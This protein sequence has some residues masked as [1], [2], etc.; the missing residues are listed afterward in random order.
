MLPGIDRPEGS[1][2]SLHQV[3]FSSGTV[4]PQ[5]LQT[6]AF[7]GKVAP[8]CLHLRKCPRISWVGLLKCSTIR[9]NGKTPDNTPHNKGFFPLEIASL[10]PTAAGR[11]N[12]ISKKIISFIT[13]PSFIQR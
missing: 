12:N 6:E 9:K 10:N 8:H 4:V 2:Q 13:Y 7:Q 3:V 11:P 5:Y 1:A